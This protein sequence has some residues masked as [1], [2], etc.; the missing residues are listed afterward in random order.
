MAHEDKYTGAQIIKT[1]EQLWTQRKTVEQIWDVIERFIMPYRGRFF[2]EIHSEHAVEW[3]KREVY[4]STAVMAAQSLAASLHG[5]LTT[6]AIRWFELRFRDADLAKNQEAR[7]WLE[8]SG[9]RVYDALQDSNFNLETNETYLD[10]VGYGTSVIVEEAGSDPTEAWKGI[11]FMSLPLKQAYFE[12]DENAQIYRLFRLLNWPTSRYLDKFGAE[13]CPDII[14]KKH[15]QNPDETV[16]VIFCIYPVEA[17]KDA[18]TAGVL[19]AEARPFAFKYVLRADGEAFGGPQGSGGYYEMPAFA[20]RWRKTSESA[21]GN[22]PAMIALADVL[23]LNQVVEMRIKAIEKRID[24]PQKV[25]ERALLTDLM[26]QARGITVLRDITKLAPIDTGADINAGEI[27]I[28]DLRAAI[29]SYFFVDQLE[30]KESPAM[31]ATEVQVRAEMMQRLLGPTLG[32][33]QS[34][35]LDLMIQRTFNIMLRAGQL[36]AIPEA[37]GDA[38]SAMDIDYMGPL[39]RAQKTD[40]AASTERWLMNLLSVSEVIPDVLDVPDPDAIA[41]EIAS[42]LSVPAGMLRDEQQVIEIREARQAA[43]QAQQEAMQAQE[44]GAGMEAMGKG[45][46]ALDV[47]S[48]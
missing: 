46:Q 37:V 12:L 23:T 19:A 20:P 26:L 8:D 6:P 1:F 9:Q 17:N 3:R 4:D 13:N 33:L 27:E 40:R 29:R 15:E 39:S 25:E 35:Y 16:E 34:D 10:L 48:G 41:R 47:V 36:Q 38:N 32:R 44:A 21:W 24:P 22:S 11:N 5:S 14:V 2:K 7:E 43:Q 42:M 45:E 30:L 18:D 31:T 28:A